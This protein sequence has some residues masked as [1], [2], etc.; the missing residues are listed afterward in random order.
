MIAPTKGAIKYTHWCSNFPEINAGMIDR[1]GFI[2]APQIGPA[3]KT[4]NKTVE[5]IAIP[6]NIPCSLLPFAT[7]K[8]TKTN[9]KAK[10]ISKTNALLSETIGMV[11]PKV[12]EVGNRIFK[13]KL[14]KNAPIT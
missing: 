13:E 2:D 14:A 6:A 10:I 7:C 12:G 4:S 8:I 5:P 9:T 11:S 3:N 1:I